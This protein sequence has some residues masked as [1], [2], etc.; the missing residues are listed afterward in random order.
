M[1]LLLYFVK[2]LSLSFLVNL[3]QF[4]S[5]YNSHLTKSIQKEYAFGII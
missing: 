5:S 4:N 3:N 1:V 2:K